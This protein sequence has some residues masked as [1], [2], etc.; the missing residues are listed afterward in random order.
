[1]NRPSESFTCCLIRPYLKEP[2]TR[3]APRRPTTNKLHSS[4]NCT[5]I[6]HHIDPETPDYEHQ[7]CWPPD[8]ST[9][10]HNHTKPSP[11]SPHKYVDYDTSP[12]ET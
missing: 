3:L 10:G 7:L 5:E 1:M 2:Y 4:A 11:A 9:H 8:N 12:S 6:H